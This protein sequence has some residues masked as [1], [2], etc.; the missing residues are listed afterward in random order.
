MSASE[1]RRATL[2]QQLHTTYPRRGFDNWMVW[3]GGMAVRVDGRWCGPPL[4]RAFAGGKE[5]AVPARIRVEFFVGALE[6]TTVRCG[7]V[8]A[9]LWTDVNRSD[10]GH[11]LP[12]HLV[13]D[14]EGVPRLAG[15]NLVFESGDFHLGATGVFSFTVEFS[16]D[17]RP[18]NDIAPHKDGV[19]VVSPAW[20]REGP[21]II[22]VCVRK[23]GARQQG[24][25]FSGTF[26]HL[27]RDQGEGGSGAFRH[28]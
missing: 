26:T 21:S 14:A 24:G 1:G 8:E 18:L 5:P 15:Q 16:A 27:Q 20:V 22:E 3:V 13:C 17:P 25:R 9:R 19:L 7:D 28:L 6:A 23:A 4:A 11:Y 10:P 12:M 2:Y